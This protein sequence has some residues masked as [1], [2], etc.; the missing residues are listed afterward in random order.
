MIAVPIGPDVRMAAVGAPSYFEKH[1]PPRTPHDLAEHRCIKLR[2]RTLGGFYAWELEKSGRE[3]HVR[4]EG[5]V[6]FNDAR[7]IINAARAGLGIAYVFADSVQPDIAEGALVAV[8][9]DWTPPFVGY[10][11]YYPSR[12]QQSAA[13]T[14]LVDA[15]RYRG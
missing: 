3:L 15:L 4:V 5:Q 14:V 10:H 11:L 8:L 1:P 13:F 7:L 9:S 6:A 2:L 12:R